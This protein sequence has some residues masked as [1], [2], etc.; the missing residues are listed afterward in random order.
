MNKR[1][2]KKSAKLE[3]APTS[4]NTATPGS[5]VLDSSNPTPAELVE[6]VKLP[7]QAPSTATK[8]VALERCELV[9]ETN[10]NSFRNCCEAMHE[11]SSKHLYKAKYKTFENYCNKRW[12]FSRS[13]GYALVK[14]HQT[15]AKVSTK[16][17][18]FETITNGS[19]AK[20][21][22]K[23]P[24]KL[25]AEV[26]KNAAKSAG[27][28]KLTGRHIKECS[29]AIQQELNDTNVV[30]LPKESADSLIEAVTIPEPTTIPMPHHSPAEG[31]VWV[32]LPA[33]YYKNIKNLP[34]L[35]ELSKD[36]I[37][38]DNLRSN[39]SRKTDYER[40]SMKLK[41]W[42]PIYAEWERECLLITKEQQKA[43]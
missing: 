21:L 17:D 30:E 22:A 39:P 18:T 14:A 5:K 13:Y 15:I 6:V 20:A 2:S 36:A 42:L 38:A 23:V 43:A 28:G 16:A 8:E 29:T 31:M 32:Q 40:L 34:S 10:Q 24:E 1:T 25:R 27:K 35:Q 3:N 12:G 4:P 41:T 26:V 9:Y 7:D 37:E 19:Q 33:T 11:I